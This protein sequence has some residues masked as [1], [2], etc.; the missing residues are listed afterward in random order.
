VV[1]KVYASLAVVRRVY[2]RLLAIHTATRV[3][4]CQ[5][6]VMERSFAVHGFRK[7]VYTLPIDPSVVRVEM[8]YLKS[9]GAHEA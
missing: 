9:D 2:M 3:V 1:R 6:Q 5:L 8:V 7:L 4:F